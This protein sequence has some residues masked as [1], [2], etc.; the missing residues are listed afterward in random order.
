[1]WLDVATDKK[2]AKKAPK[3]DATKPLKAENMKG[4]DKEDE[5]LDDVPDVTQD[6][7]KDPNLKPFFIVLS[8]KGNRKVFMSKQ[9]LGIDRV[10]KIKVNPPAKNSVFLFDK[11]TNTIRLASERNF[12]LSNKMGKGMKAGHEA[13]FRRILNSKITADQVL[14]MGKKNIHN[15]GKKCLDVNGKNAD[16]ASL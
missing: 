11:R 3:V 6:D 8:G 9:K 2:K 5:A 10:A 12:V 13:V 1:M 15:K 14:V 16:M 4:D 7:F